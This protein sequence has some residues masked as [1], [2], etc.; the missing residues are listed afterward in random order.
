MF[1]KHFS[2]LL[3]IWAW[4]GEHDGIQYTCSEWL[5]VCGCGFLWRAF[6]EPTLFMSRA[7]K[8]SSLE[9]AFLKLL[10]VCQENIVLWKV[11]PYGFRREMVQ[12][13]A[14]IPEM[15]FVVS[16]WKNKGGFV[17]GSCYATMHLAIALL[18]LIT[19]DSCTLLSMQVIYIK[20]PS[21]WFF[22]FIRN[23]G[24]VLNYVVCGIPEPW[25]FRWQ[26]NWIP[27]L[28][29]CWGLLKKSCTW[30]QIN[31]SGS[32]M[33]AP[34]QGQ[35]IDPTYSWLVKYRASVCPL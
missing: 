18:D 8:W 1:P 26:Y 30:H 17:L 28:W 33:L 34:N 25:P 2:L 32:Y 12:A 21:H 10:N 27:A 5:P 35:K 29:T 6:E 24:A 19:I 15:L 16:T 14:I 22:L 3:S 11:P 4:L 9:W 23:V 7:M 20:Q 31:V 13:P